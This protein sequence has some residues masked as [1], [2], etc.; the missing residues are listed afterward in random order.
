MIIEQRNIY[1]AELLDHARA[2]E[3]DN[4]ATVDGGDERPEAKVAANVEDACS[5][6]GGKY[7]FQNLPFPFQV[8]ADAGY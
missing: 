8:V 7:W 4:L 1:D 6:E 3:T 2:I 5:E